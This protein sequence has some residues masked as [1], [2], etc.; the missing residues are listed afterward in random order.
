MIRN[1]SKDLALRRMAARI[2][3]L[4]EVANMELLLAAARGPDAAPPWLEMLEGAVRSGA[5]PNREMVEP[6]ASS[7][8][9]Q[10][11]GTAG[12]VPRHGHSPLG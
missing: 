8:S 4:G 7:N 2:T 9:E 1:M 3:M 12:A 11:A 10:K 5:L 6:E